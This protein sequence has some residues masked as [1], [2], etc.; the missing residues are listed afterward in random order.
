MKRAVY[1]V[2]IGLAM[3]I[4]LMPPLLRVRAATEPASE[5]R[6]IAGLLHRS[7]GIPTTDSP[8]A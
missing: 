1:V 6:N 2:G 7:D 4:D 3:T 5:A 8:L